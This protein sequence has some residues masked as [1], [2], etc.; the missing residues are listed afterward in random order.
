MKKYALLF[1][2]LIPSVVV[3]DTGYDTEM[4]MLDAQIESLTRER[5]KKYTDLKQCEKTTKGFKIAGITTLVATGFGI[6]GNIKL[7]QKLKN[8]GAA[9]Y[10]S[11]V[12]V[13]DTRPQ[14]EKDEESCELG[15][16]A[17]PEKFRELCNC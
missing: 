5:D 13:V 14:E 3:A 15:C 1:L 10:I 8:N 2:L 7:A 6:Y 17:E 11:S 9:S 4:Q 12:A 16:M